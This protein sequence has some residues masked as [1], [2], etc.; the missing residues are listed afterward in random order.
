MF[1]APN[2][3]RPAPAGSYPAWGRQMV[4]SLPD[5]TGLFPD[6]RQSM[7]GDDGSSPAPMLHRSIA[8]TPMPIGLIL[9][10]V[11]GPTAL[12]HC[13]SLG[14]GLPHQGDGLP[15]HRRDMVLVA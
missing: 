2:S 15:R 9:Q 13:G 11:A 6:P 7:C 5:A 3:L 8:Q 14:G 1:M 4:T 10:T 12:L